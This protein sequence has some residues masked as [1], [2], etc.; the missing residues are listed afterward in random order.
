M[1]R[2]ILAEDHQVVRNGIKSLLEKEEDLQVI[3][4][5][6]NG[7]EVIAYLEG[8][9]KV[10]IILADIN[11]PEMDGLQLAAK[12]SDS[13][14]VVKIII[15]SMMDN[16]NYVI[17]AFETGVN[18]Y[19]LKNVDS[20]EMMFAIRHVDRGNRYL[21]SEIC[22]KM[23]NKAIRL[24]QQPLND[25]LADIEFT[26]RELE[27]LVLTADGFT[28]NEIAEKLF[29]SRRTVEGHRQ[30]LIDK[31]GV[32]NTAALIQFAFRAGIIK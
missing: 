19:L 2:I 14:P 8:G 7:Q 26:P 11:M 9:A 30:S 17:E 32:R 10:D 1:I 3:G 29:T 15:L 24:M 12:L 13:Y 20:E 21:C 5:A 4:E 31:T 23:F 28:N 22:S 6:E 25:K 18:G 27:I 16:E